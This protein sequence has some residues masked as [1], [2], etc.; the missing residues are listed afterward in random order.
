[1]QI[2]KWISPFGDK[3]FRPALAKSRYFAAAPS[4]PKKLAGQFSRA[5]PENGAGANGFWLHLTPQ[6]KIPGFL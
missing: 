4:A 1:M 3:R 2:L 6:R 5:A